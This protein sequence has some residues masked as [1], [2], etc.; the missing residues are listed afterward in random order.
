MDLCFHGRCEA[1]RGFFWSCRQPHSPAPT[2][3]YLSQI[4][5]RVKRG[6]NALERAEKLLLKM[7]LSTKSQRFLPRNLLFPPTSHGTTSIKLIFF[8][9]PQFPSF[10]P[11]GN[12]WE[13]RDEGLGGR[14]KKS[15]LLPMIPE[16]ERKGFSGIFP[17]FPAGTSPPWLPKIASL[18]NSPSSPVMRAEN[19]LENLENSHPG[20]GT[21]N[22]T[23]GIS[24]LFR[25]YPKNQTS[26]AVYPPPPAPPRAIFPQEK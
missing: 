12:L 3:A 13:L 6:L 26:D 4:K 15:P 25:I 2:R 16:K 11:D 5:P 8:F 10:Q 17:F 18:W 7:E 24:D 9:F 1:A 19:Q 23:A 21:V 20:S 22:S 14:R